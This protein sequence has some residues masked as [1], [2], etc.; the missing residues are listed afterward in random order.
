MELDPPIGSLVEESFPIDVPRT[1][2]KKEITGYPF[3][4]HEDK[5]SQY[6]TKE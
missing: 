4:K 1:H 5:S 2:L 3:G 6:E